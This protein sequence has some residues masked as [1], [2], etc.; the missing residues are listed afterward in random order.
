GDPNCNSQEALDFTVAASE[1]WSEGYEVL[2]IAP[3]VKYPKDSNYEED[4]KKLT[5][6]L[7]N[8]LPKLRNNQIIIDA[9]KEYVEITDEIIINALTWGEGPIIEIQDLGDD[10]DGNDVYGKY[11]GIVADVLG[12]ELLNTIFLDIDLVNKFENSE[13]EDI[14]KDALGFLIGV[15][16]LHEYIHLSDF[17]YQDDFWGID[18]EE[19]G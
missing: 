17:V 15:T 11:K 4:Y 10:V 7:K 3:L 8:E 9:I 12:E 6:Y 2:S 14:S 1:A 5:R 19:E 18:G 16:I 13:E